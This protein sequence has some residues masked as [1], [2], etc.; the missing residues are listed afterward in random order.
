MKLFKIFSLLYF[1]ET[2]IAQEGVALC[3]RFVLS[4]GYNY[5]YSDAA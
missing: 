5:S 1:R 4:F 2:T 3:A